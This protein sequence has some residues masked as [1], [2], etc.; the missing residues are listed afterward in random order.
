MG[1]QFLP[2]Q[3]RIFNWDYPIDGQLGFQSPASP[4]MEEIINFHNYTMIYLTFVVISVLWILVEILRQFVKTNVFISHKFM[5][6]GTIIEL[7]WTVTP[8]VILVGIA[9]PS[10]KLLYLMDEVIDAGLT[11]KVIGHQWYWSY[12]YSDYAS[13]DG[14]TIEFDSYMVNDDDLEL[15][16]LRLLEVDNQV[17]VPKNVHVRVIVTSADVI[18]SWAVPSLGV[19]VDAIP[20]RLNQTSF[21]AHREGVYYGQ[22]SEICGVQHAFMPIAVKVTDLDSYCNYIDELL[23]ENREE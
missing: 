15:G 7:I 1:V 13:Q 5:V 16:D 6:H 4:V 22:C 9:F 11:V 19:K 20:S 8:A 21:L 23:A 18:H 2:L 14:T 12:E 3:M 10:F 17:V